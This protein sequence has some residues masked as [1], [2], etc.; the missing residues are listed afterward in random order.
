MRKQKKNM[1]SNL[2]SMDGDR[3][4]KEHKNHD[5]QMEIKKTFANFF[6]TTKMMK[7]WKKNNRH[8]DFNRGK[9]KPKTHFM[10]RK[11]K[12]EKIIIDC[13]FGPMISAARN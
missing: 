7:I 2:D 3:G 10:K 6:V 13:A 12:Q 11:K 9:N 8:I 4:G 1:H 5:K